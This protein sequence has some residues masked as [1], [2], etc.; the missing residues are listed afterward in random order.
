MVLGHA[1]VGS[2]IPAQLLSNPNWGLLRTSPAL[3]MD[4]SRALS[5]PGKPGE[6]RSAGPGTPAEPTE[7]ALGSG[8]EGR[9][10]SEALKHF[11]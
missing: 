7:P 8:W 9:V 3:L 6:D 5:S 2:F 11:I 10:L 1:A 4:H